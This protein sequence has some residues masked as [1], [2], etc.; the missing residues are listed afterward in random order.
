MLL[1]RPFETSVST[2]I[3]TLQVHRIE[4]SSRRKSSHDELTKLVSKLSE[5]KH[6]ESSGK[7]LSKILV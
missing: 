7:Q 4:L 3:P 1:E 5:P 2:T 6:D